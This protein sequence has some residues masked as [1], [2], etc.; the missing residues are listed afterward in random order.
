MHT[1]CLAQLYSSKSS[2]A[3]PDDS[4][5]QQP[6]R[7]DDWNKL[8]WGV[9]P[10]WNKMSCSRKT[11]TEQ[12]VVWKCLVLFKQEINCSQ[13]FTYFPNWLCDLRKGRTALPDLWRRCR[14]RL[15]LDFTLGWTLGRGRKQTAFCKYFKNV[16]RTLQL[17]VSNWAAGTKKHFFW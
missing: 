1:T 8:V 11:T 13:L 17:F 9:R 4:Q 15:I 6:S 16:R 5:S 14:N 12:D 2:W 7:K 3:N 10:K